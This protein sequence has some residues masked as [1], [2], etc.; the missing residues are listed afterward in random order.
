MLFGAIMQ[1]LHAQQHM[2]CL[3]ECRQPR[4]DPMGVRPQRPKLKGTLVLHR[5]TPRL[6]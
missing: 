4:S 1:L 3:M 5:G 6:L 2:Q